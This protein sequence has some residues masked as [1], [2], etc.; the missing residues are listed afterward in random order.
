[1]PDTPVRRLRLCAQPG[2]SD[3]AALNDIH[4]LLT[5]TT[6]NGQALLGDIAAV[7]ARSGRPMAR[8][9]DIEVT[10]SQTPT[11]WPVAHVDAGDTTVI[12]RQDPASHGLLIAI[13]TRAP[14]ERDQ[15]T[16]TLDDRCL[17]RASPPGDPAA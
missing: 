16:V 17:H 11:G 4:A 15:L 3:T 1:M 5:T 10:T 7:L 2:Y 9:R 12:V 14:A 8:A 6:D 13:T